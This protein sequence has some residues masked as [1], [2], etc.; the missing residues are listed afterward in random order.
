V[1]FKHAAENRAKNVPAR[2]ILD[3]EAFSEVATPAKGSL[4][5]KGKREL[6]DDPFV[7]E[8]SSLGAVISAHVHPESR[9]V[10]AKGSLDLEYQFPARSTAL[11]DNLTVAP[12]T[13]EQIPQFE[14]EAWTTTRCGTNAER[15]SQPALDDIS[16]GEE[17]SGEVFPKQGFTY[18]NL[19]LLVQKALHDRTKFEGPVSAS[20]LQAQG[21]FPTSRYG[22]V[23]P[24]ARSL[25]PSLGPTIAN[26][27]RIVRPQSI[28]VTD[29]AIDVRQAKTPQNGESEGATAS[30]RFSEPDGL[31][32]DQEYE[33]ANGLNQQAPTVQK[34]KGPFFAASKPTASDPTASLSVH[35]GEEE[36]LLAWFCDGHRPAR[37]REYAMTL[38]SGATTGGR[39]LGIIGETMRATHNGDYENTGPFVR[40]Y[41]GLSEY[42]EEFHNGI[43]ESYFNRAW[44]AAP[45]HLRDFDMNA[46]SSYF[47][48]TITTSSKLH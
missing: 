9:T 37:Q 26:P 6:L 15:M 10:D 20:D 14:R 31:C 7:A 23:Q 35:I 3:F 25:F 34:F 24:S 42:I 38:V 33:I 46:N 21:S 48:A 19:H 45:S 5:T 8:A 30:I 4:H 32:R 43:R 18:R 44:R 36:K 12:I 47:T 39:C 22:T 27:R 16:L 1:Y 40:L 29:R 17:T 13:R 11:S 2:R 28:A 41:E